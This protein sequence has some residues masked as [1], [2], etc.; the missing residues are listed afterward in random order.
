VFNEKEKLTME[1]PGSM[2]T[3]NGAE[4]MGVDDISGSI[5]KGKCAHL[6]VPDRNILECS[7]EDLL[8]TRV[9]LLYPA[10]SPACAPFPSAN[11]E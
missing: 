4:L 3:I 8:E 1:E 10:N 9:F 5:E 2:L 7:P 11:S 6:V